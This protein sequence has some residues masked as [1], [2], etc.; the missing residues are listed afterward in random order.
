MFLEG[1]QWASEHPDD[2]LA[3]ERRPHLPFLEQAVALALAAESAGNLPI[4]AVIVLKGE[5]IAQGQ[6]SLLEPHYHPGRHGE[7]EALKQVPA[8]LWRQAS[9]MVC[10]TTLEPCVMC[11][12]SLLLHGVGKIIFGATDPEGGFRTIESALPTF[13]YNHARPEWQGP[14]YPEICD[15]LYQRAKRL[16]GET[17]VGRETSQ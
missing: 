14:L 2:A 6:N 13:Y 9:A 7:I 1:A 5:V 11:Y 17:P 10:Y 3:E 15:P 8:P 12:G 4:G 16:F